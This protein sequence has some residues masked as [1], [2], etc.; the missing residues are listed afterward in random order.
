MQKEAKARILINDLLR[1][2]GWRFF[3]DETGP[4]NIAL[5][6]N[7]KIKKAAL[8]ALGDDFEKTANGFIDY[9]LLDE[10]GFPLAVLEA[11]SEKHDPLVGKEQARKYA[12]SQNVRF[13]ILSNGNLHYFWD[14]EQGNPVLITE[15]PNPESFAHFHAFKPNPDTLASEKVETDYV[16]ITQNPNYAHDP[17]WTDA[18][19]R[20]AFIKDAELK[21]LRPY[22]MR[23][24]GA[25]QDAVRKGQ[26]RFLFEMATGTGKTLTAAA[27]I[28]MF[29][30]TG[31]AKR[32]L[33]LVDRLELETQ[34]WK[35][36][37]RLLKNDFRTVIYKENRDDWRKAEIVVST[38]QS[39]QFNNKYRRLFSPTD[40]DLLIS[41]EAHR[42]IGGNSRAVFEYF[43][44][45]KLGLTAT[46]K[47][48]LKKIDP[49]RI[50]E[51]DPR[52]WERRQLLDTYKTFGCESGAPSFRY[53]LT[54]GV[55]DGFL[56]N[57][58]VVDARTEITT[59]LLAEEGYSVMQQNEDGELV[60]QTFFG[61][62][63]EKKF[64]SDETNRVFCET[65]LKNALRDPL[66]GE[67]GK[68]IIFCV[69][70]DHA[71]RIVQKLNELA[72]ALHPG[73]YNS[74][75]A[76]QVT[77]AVQDA[78]QMAASFAN[79]N[80]NGHTRFLEG[81]ISS[82]TRVCVTVGMM[83]TGYDCEDL[84]NVV[85]LRPIF[86]PTDFIQ[87]KGRGTR[88]YTFRYTEK[89][90]G[91]VQDHT[92][93]KEKFK[94]FD[95]FAVCEYFEEKFNYDEEIKLPPTRG[96]GEGPTPPPPP[97]P[98]AGGYTNVDPDPLKTQVEYDVPVYGMKIDRKFF[99]RF[100][101]QVKAA[102]EVRQ[103]YEQGDIKGAEEAVIAELFNKPEDF[104]NLDKL[105]KAVQAD[106]RITLRE[107]LAKAFG[108]IERFK[109]KDELLEEELSKF[110]SIHKPDAPHMPVIRQFFKAYVT[111]GGVR[112]IVDAREFGRLADN[113]KVSIGDIKALNGWRDVIP[114][115]V[116]DYVPLNA[117]AA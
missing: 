51:R 88:K 52:E 12:L 3:A 29:L 46:P 57:P 78:Q 65:F 102:P 42:S 40:F 30:R 24:V 7:V 4:A 54:D 114:E 35:A 87:I 50:N 73:K 103:R 117:F 37:V 53:S 108:E 32:V 38:V 20:D 63:F 26:T 74:D 80:L 2:S 48:Y 47:D 17:R 100:E 92:K 61:K 110:V 104:F 16:A 19:Q 79:N 107:I 33:F 109:T 58:V 101:E 68:T 91:Q 25:L 77:S 85:L 72:H 28:K 44:G 59:E 62:D 69:R 99:E 97:P 89:E 67:I 81:Y 22:Q 98:P 111:D 27:V 15:F 66:S 116:K 23:A 64:F 43:I 49:A 82:K 93:P 75:F 71:T 45:Y 21:F 8:D 60:E 106:R 95:F 13:V 84:L 112:A 94:L 76:V 36:F 55:R 1:R 70:Q 10:R 31:N 6:A 14:L 39:L 115:Y 113:P 5:E 9:L 34:A 83:T 90:G 41:D 56:L 18:A 86:S 105:R 96:G 11:K